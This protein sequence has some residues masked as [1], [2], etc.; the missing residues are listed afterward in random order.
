M[1]AQQTQD[2]FKDVPLAPEDA[3]FALTAGF[4]ADQSEH[5]INL[6]SSTSPLSSL[7]SYPC[8]GDL[9]GSVLLLLLGRG[10][11]PESG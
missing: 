3:I 9:R 6:G 11:E 5:K 1:P 7:R 4:K 8:S 10:G 2:A